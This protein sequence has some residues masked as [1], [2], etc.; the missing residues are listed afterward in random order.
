MRAIPGTTLTL[1]F[2]FALAGCATAETGQT[3]VSAIKMTVEATPEKIAH[4]ILTVGCEVGTGPLTATAVANTPGLYLLK[5]KDGWKNK[6]A[7]NGISHPTWLLRLG[8]D[9]DRYAVEQNGDPY[10]H[11]YACG[12]NYLINKWDGGPDIVLNGQTVQDN[13]SDGPWHSFK[14]S[15]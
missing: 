1:I 2:V 6:D 7:P 9:P 3:E 13:L 8:P 4:A 15:Q 12:N 11:S 5:L 14:E 10:W